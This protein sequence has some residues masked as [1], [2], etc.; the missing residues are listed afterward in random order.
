MPKDLP[1]KRNGE[2]KNKSTGWA[3]RSSE[4]GQFINSSGKIGQPLT[5]NT[6]GPK[7]EVKGSP[8][9]TGSNVKK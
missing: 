6:V 7:G 2:V 3:K 9:N 5:K 8:P 1:S 4:T